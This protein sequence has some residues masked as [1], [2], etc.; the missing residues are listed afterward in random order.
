MSLFND[1]QN[2]SVGKI[3]SIQPDKL[4]PDMPKQSGSL[5]TH[6]SITG[7]NFRERSQD[8]QRNNPAMLNAFN[9]NPYT[10]S[11]YSVA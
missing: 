8:C 4:V 3:G 1:T 11:L 5:A 10:K 9:N 6:G 2:V 7:R